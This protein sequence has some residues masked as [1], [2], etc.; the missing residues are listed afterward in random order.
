MQYI[1]ILVFQG[2]ERT[3]PTRSETI[4][5][6]VGRPYQT[7]QI[8]NYTVLK[9]QTVLDPLDQKLYSSQ[10]ADR[11][12]P[13]RSETIQ[14]SGGRPYQTHQIRNYTFLRVQ[15][16]LDP[17]D[18]KLYSSQ[19]ADRRRCIII[20]KK[21]ILKTYP[22]PKRSFKRRVCASNSGYTDL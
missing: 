19:G 20:L 17:L 7:H 21:P 12:R 14:F 5:F 18:Q 22:P 6:S 4:H 15:T 2:A 8:R 3:R 10:G 11:T 16:V 13:T 1:T 9:G